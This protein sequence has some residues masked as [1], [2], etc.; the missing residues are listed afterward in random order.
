[1]RCINSLANGYAD[2]KG[3]DNIMALDTGGATAD[4][5]SNVGDNPLYLFPGDDDRRKVK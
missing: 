5:Y 1:M 3:L 2:Q 4:F